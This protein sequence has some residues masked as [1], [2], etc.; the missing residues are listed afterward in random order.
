MR[1][2]EFIIREAIS[3]NLNASRKEEAIR[4]MVENLRTAGYFKGQEAEDVVKAILKR[5]ML[6][7]TGIGDGVAIPHAKHSSVDRLV[8]T[9]A[10]SQKGIPFDSVDNEPVHVFVM[11]ISPQ[12]RPSDDLRALEGVSRC[13][14]D[15]N[16]V[17][18][19][20]QATTPQQIWEL[21]CNH[22]RGA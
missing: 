15:K 7:S 11:L 8:G 10:L 14:K 2:S 3:A 4:E 13:L 12:E 17:Q 16:F 20:R 1:M 19:L 9:V 18:S 5:E 22:D 21:I 6:S